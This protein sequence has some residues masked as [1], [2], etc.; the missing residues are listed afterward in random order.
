MTEV[1]QVSNLN[2]ILN[3]SPEA[4][5]LIMQSRS[6]SP[7][8]NDLEIETSKESPES[9]IKI[10]SADESTEKH[11]RKRS[12]VSRACD[13]CRKKKVKCDAEL[14]GSNE[15]L[16]ICSNC[17][18]TKDICQFTR[19]PRKRGPVKGYNRRKGSDASISDSGKP[20][21]L[22]QTQAQ[23]L[24]GHLLLP[25]T[26]LNN[27]NILPFGNQA[28]VILP[29]LNN[30][31]PTHRQYFQ[32]S[33]ERPRSL[34]AN[35]QSTNQKMFW[36][37]P[38]SDRPP[39]SDRGSIDST[40]SSFKRKRF[41][42]SSYAS[43]VDYSDSDDE[44]LNQS[45]KKVSTPGAFQ[46]PISNSSNHQLFNN[47]NSVSN[48][49]VGLNHLNSN[50]VSAGGVSP[51]G[52]IS[53]FNNT[54]QGMGNLTV[55][56]SL[57]N[58]ARSSIIAPALPMYKWQDVWGLV[59]VNIDIYFNIFHPFFPVIPSKDYLMNSCYKMDRD[60]HLCILKLLANI[61]EIFQNISK[62]DLSKILNDLK[63]NC[64]FLVEIS[65]NS[66]FIEN[67]ENAKI[68]FTTCLSLLTYA[69]VLSGYKYTLP[70]AIAFSYFRD[71]SIFGYPVT[72][73]N[74]NNLISVV[75]LDN[76]FSLH[77]GTPRIG[78]VC[79]SID[80][81]FINEFF[82]NSLICK[83]D[84]LTPNKNIEYF[85]IGLNLVLHA[86]KL[87]ELQ[88]LDNFYNLEYNNL[89]TKF[90][91]ILK[92]ISDL[93]NQFHAVPEQIKQITDSNI[94]S[95]NNE[96]L[97]NYILNM[98]LKIAKF[99]KKINNIIDEQLDDFE[100]STPH[101]LL[102]IMV[103]KCAKTLRN[104]QTITKSVSSLNY[105]LGIDS[106]LQDTNNANFTDVNMNKLSGYSGLPNIVPTNNQQ[107][108]PQSP[109][110]SASSF[111]NPSDRFKKFTE[112]IE[113]NLQRCQTIN[114]P[115]EIVKKEIESIINNK[116][117]LIVKRITVG[118][119]SSDAS[120][121][122]TQKNSFNDK[123]SRKGIIVKDVITLN[124]VRMVNDFWSLEISKEGLDGWRS[125]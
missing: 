93:I 10:L 57:T 48:V 35:S 17:Q 54:I 25:N 84:D 122:S 116:R 70:F 76:I 23:N 11:G 121:Y 108:S 4:G 102:P 87:Q 112:A 81:N 24:G 117:D 67:D 5:E 6:N 125:V 94:S 100:L 96:Q 15:V 89:K 50:S 91:Q 28:Q 8:L 77:F 61:L 107:N 9:Q 119:S 20:S 51:K 33:V 34:S 65:I 30:L 41:N 114:L 88:T 29:P 118:G 79:F 64:D 16:K 22:L 42:G 111:S 55:A 95:D 99:V 63:N 18:K 75:L 110:L 7:S 73:W 103:I 85:E 97:M 82:E 26:K 115:N 72:N 53:T 59:S 37:A 105:A 38:T 1:E 109:Q 74:F 56:S 40:N 60:E 21:L 124:W 44:F 71:W 36:K 3:P 49:G 39:R 27:T 113:L 66:S 98:E 90:F 2:S 101:P 92:S 69:V 31:Q 43:S 123:N 46:F 19:I 106:S 86:N 104:L 52:S 32:G 78:T 47:S 12:K 62:G 83:S 58:S 45:S 120:K 13:A 14:G 80:T 68:V